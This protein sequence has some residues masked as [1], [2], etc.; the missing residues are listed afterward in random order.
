MSASF[1]PPTWTPPTNPVV[2]EPLPPRRRPRRVALLAAAAVGAS[3]AAGGALVA[4]AGGKPGAT[5][6]A[7]PEAA[8]GQSSGLASWAR[9]YNGEL[10]RISTTMTDDLQA[11]SDAANRTDVYD[12]TEACATLSNDVDDFQDSSASR[13]VR[14]PQ[15]WAT[16]LDDAQTVAH[17]CL[18]GDYAGTAAASSAVGDDATLLAAQIR[19]VTG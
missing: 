12:L 9:V 14:A 18:V 15:L 19:A 13:D 1:P 5:A 11:I 17:D 3:L 10:M 16:M 7:Q 2:A 4:S 6:A 8:V